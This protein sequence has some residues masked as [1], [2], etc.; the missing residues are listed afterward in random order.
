MGGIGEIKNRVILA[1][2]TRG[3]CDQASQVPAEVNVEYYKQRA[4]FLIKR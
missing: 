2:L 4:K 3:R 1:P